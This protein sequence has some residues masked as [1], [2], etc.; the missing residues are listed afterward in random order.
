MTT[1]QQQHQPLRGGLDTSTT[2]GTTSSNIPNQIRPLNMEP[3][4][5]EPH[6]SYEERLMQQSIID[7]DDD[8][9]FHSRMK[10]KHHRYSNGSS[11]NNSSSNNIH[12]HDGMHHTS[13]SNSIDNLK[14]TVRNSASHLNHSGSSNFS[15]P[16]NNSSNNINH[17]SRQQQ[18]QQNSHNHSTK[19][20]QNH[21][22]EAVRFV[23]DF[24][25]VITAI[26]TKTSVFVMFL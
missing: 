25:C 7:D 23:C 1:P 15:L 21:D 8:I 17:H 4:P 3:D 16:H 11:H 12:R 24:I 10:N 9:D 20:Q 19:A 22:T 14:S 13:S 2:T 18:Q 5:M 26:T 6:F